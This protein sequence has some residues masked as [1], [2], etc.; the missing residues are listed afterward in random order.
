[1]RDNLDS[2][3][4]SLAMTINTMLRRLLST[5]SDLFRRPSRQPESDS[6]A[7]VQTALIALSNPKNE[8]VNWLLGAVLRGGAKR[9]D[10]CF[11][12][13]ALSGKNPHAV[14]AWNAWIVEF[15]SVLKD[16]EL[17]VRKVISELSNRPLSGV[18]DFMTEVLAV[19]H[20]SRKGYTEFEPVLASDGKPAVD[21]RA[22]RDVKL[23]R[24]EVKNLH[25]PQDIIRTVAQT[26]WKKRRAENPQ[27]FSMPVM[28]THSHHGPL[29]DKAISR[30]NNAIDEIPTVSRDERKIV[31]DG[32]IPITITRLTE[33]RIKASGSEAFLLSRMMTAGRSPGIVVQSPIR[34]DDLEFDLS[35]LQLL[36]VKAFRVVADA[37]DKFFGR[38]SDPDAED[39]IIMRWEAPKM[40]YDEGTPQIVQNAIESA[41][42]AVELQLKV[43]ILGSD[44]EP[45]FKFTRGRDKST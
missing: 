38:H 1:M 39:V 40:F 11:L 30:L 7:E 28:L 4:A 17:A 34:V 20:L 35:E 29:S 44:P 10:T 22:R 37:A 27:K 6:L 33:E 32:G 31:L 23:V 9:G 42:A 21:F 12:L 43:V 24:I 18:A 15:R 25:E 26:R 19:L 13:N 3:V 2:V 16:P 36:F 41:F 5:V 45:N 8:P 14:E